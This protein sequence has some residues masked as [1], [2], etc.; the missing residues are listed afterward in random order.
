MG[1]HDNLLGKTASAELEKKFSG[2]GQVTK[3]TPKAFI[4]L[5]S[6]D[7]SVPPANGT[8]YYLALVKNRVP[9][10]L[11]AYP[12]GGHGWGFRDRFI[13]KRQWTGELEKWLR[14]EILPGCLSC[15]KDVL[16]N[17]LKFIGTPYVANTLEVNDEEKL[18]VNLN[19]V[20]CT[21]FVEY[22]LAQSMEGDFTCDL[23]RIRYRNGKIDGYTSRLHYIADWVEN[24]IRQGIIEDVTAIHSP[25]RQKLSISYM[26]THPQLYKALKSSPENVK[27]M[28]E[29]E[30]A[31]TGKSICY[32]PKDKLNAE[33]LPWIEDGDIIALCTDIP[34]LDV[35][36]MGIAVYKNGK[37]HLL[38]ASSV[39][40]KVE[41]SAVP[42]SEMLARSK[43]NTGIRVLRSTKSSL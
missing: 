28:E 9:V 21:T 38:H 31:L 2:E 22:V 32:L 15:P 30:K 13:Y 6:D 43:S 39:N 12:T 8:N 19:Q 7:A 29:Y 37:L 5:S 27:R 25:H 16:S 18:V 4:A 20:D 26:S 14:E 23:Q 17:G 11:H 10:S 33:G 40:K 41:I 35:S 42:L 3:E 34:G 36:H 24:G 1:S